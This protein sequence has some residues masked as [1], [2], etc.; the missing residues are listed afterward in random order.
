MGTIGSIIEV[1]Y[2]VKW[3]SQPPVE[4]ITFPQ[5]CFITNETHTVLARVWILLWGMGGTASL[6]NFYLVVEGKSRS[7]KTILRA[8]SSAI[9]HNSSKPSPLF[10]DIQLLFSFL[11]SLELT[12]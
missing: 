4:T 1:V 10:P 2:C 3:P 9:V 5:M 11:G 6:H 8:V 7:Y 12:L